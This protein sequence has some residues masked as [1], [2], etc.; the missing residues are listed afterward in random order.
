MHEKQ[1]AKRRAMKLEGKEMA[2]TYESLKSKEKSELLALFLLS[3]TWTFGT[4]LT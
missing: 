4:L 1:E 3:L 2:I